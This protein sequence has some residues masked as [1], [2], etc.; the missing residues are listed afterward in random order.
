[1]RAKNCCPLKY[2]FLVSQHGFFESLPFA[3]IDSKMNGYN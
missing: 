1:M 3:A 2:Y